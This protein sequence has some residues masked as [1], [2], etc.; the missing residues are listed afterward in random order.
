[1]ADY[2]YARVTGWLYFALGVL[3]LFT[4][5]LWHMFHVGGNMMYMH[6]IIGIIG[7][8]AARYG[9]IRQTRLYAITVGL[10]LLTWGA[11]GTLSPAWLDPYPLP[12][13]N[14]LHVITGIWGFY[15]IGNSMMNWVRKK[16]LS[17]TH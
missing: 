16:S 6:F 10:L 14:A 13:E 11:V 5:H 17:R 8:T 15:G 7:I 9:S 1:M 4:D 12:L 2:R 3:G